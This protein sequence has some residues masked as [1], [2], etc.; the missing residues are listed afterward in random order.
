MSPTVMVCITDLLPVPAQESGLFANNVHGCMSVTSKL[1]RQ[2]RVPKGLKHV[3]VQGCVVVEENF[4][5]VGK[6]CGREGMV[7]AHVC[8]ACRLGVC[9]ESIDVGTQHGVRGQKQKW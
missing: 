3:V 4:F 5:L 7:C 2:N 9:L 1:L 6:R 8:H